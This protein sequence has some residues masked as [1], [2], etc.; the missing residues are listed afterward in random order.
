MNQIREKRVEPCLG[1][2]QP[3]SSEMKLGTS[4]QT[5]S[6]TGPKPVSPSISARMESV[7]VN[8]LTPR[9]WK[10]QSSHPLDQIL[11]DINAGVQTRSRLNNFCSFYAFL[12]KIEPKNINEVLADSDWVTAM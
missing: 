8:P 12:S 6:R 7:S 9:S 3:N 1:Q 4:S 10:Y 2:H 11:S 5:G